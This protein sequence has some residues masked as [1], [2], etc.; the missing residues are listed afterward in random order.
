MMVAIS[1]LA[2]SILGM[3]FGN[4]PA[5]ILPLSVSDIQIRESNGADMPP[6][7]GK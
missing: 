4:Y 2:D 7:R 1:Y 6:A 3:L 5:T